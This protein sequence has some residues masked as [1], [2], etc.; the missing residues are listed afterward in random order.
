[1]SFKPIPG[2]LIVK[3]IDDA[4]IFINP[5]NIESI[6]GDNDTHGSIISLVSGKEIK[7][8]DSPTALGSDLKLLENN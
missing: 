3:T 6:I 2:Y 4:T 1:M 7:S 5:I 8:K